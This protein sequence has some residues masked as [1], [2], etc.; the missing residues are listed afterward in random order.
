VGG[1]GTLIRVEEKE[2]EDGMIMAKGERDG[3]GWLELREGE[4]VAHSSY[5]HCWRLEEKMSYLYIMQKQ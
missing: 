5:A 2:D 4:R 3:M 1:G